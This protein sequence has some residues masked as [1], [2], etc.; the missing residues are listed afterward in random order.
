[1]KRVAAVQIHCEKALRF[2][3]YSWSWQ[4]AFAHAA[5]DLAAGEARKLAELIDAPCQF[6]V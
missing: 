1:M 4:R 2:A 6:V 3:D 5:I